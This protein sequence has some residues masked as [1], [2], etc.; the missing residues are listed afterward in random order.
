MCGLGTAP[1]E[2]AMTWSGPPIAPARHL[3]G[4]SWGALSDRSTISEL[5]AHSVTPRRASAERWRS[6][7]TAEA[8]SGGRAPERDARSARPLRALCTARS[9]VVPLA[10]GVRDCRLCICQED[11]LHYEKSAHNNHSLERDKGCPRCRFSVQKPSSRTCSLECPPPSSPA[12]P[13]RQAETSACL[14]AI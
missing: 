4:D 6:H 3:A 13:Q 11:H 7:R 10:R 9:P 2:Q 1:R 8:A 14:R 12:V 5:R